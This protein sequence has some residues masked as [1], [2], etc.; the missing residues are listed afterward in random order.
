MAV[1]AVQVSTE[2]DRAAKERTHSLGALAHVLFPQLELPAVVIVPLLVEIDQQV[3]TTLDLQLFVDIK[4]GVDAQVA[5]AL[6]LVKTAAL[7]IRVRNKA[8]DAGH[9]LEEAKEGL[10]VQLSEQV[11]HEPRR[12]L[13]WL[14]LI[15]KPL[16]IPIEVLFVFVRREIGK[17][18]LQYLAFE[19]IIDHDVRK[20]LRVLITLRERTTQCAAFAGI[21][22]EVTA[23][24]LHVQH[25]AYLTVSLPQA[26]RTEPDEVLPFDSETCARALRR[27]W[28]DTVD[29]IAKNSTCI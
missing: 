3:Q 2:D 15:F 5:A 27:H 28:L 10:A 14:E 9:L 26:K 4:V 29:G 7:E 16:L 19:E 24:R 1:E 21:Q 11:S 22:S 13:M 8:F 17:D 6:G 12:N 23:D 18:R 20:R 25:Q